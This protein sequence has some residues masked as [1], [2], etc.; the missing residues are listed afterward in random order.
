MIEF[1]SDNKEIEELAMV[2]DEE[3][4]MISNMSDSGYIEYP[5]LKESGAVIHTE[6]NLNG[7]IKENTSILDAFKSSM[8]APTLV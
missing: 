8:Y 7:K 4:K 5:L 3:L 6:A 2:I 1:L